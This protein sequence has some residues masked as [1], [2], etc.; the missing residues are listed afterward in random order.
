MT[1]LPDDFLGASAPALRVFHLTRIGFP[2]LPTLLPSALRL[3]EL[4]LLDIP[5]DGYISPEAM[6][7]SLEALAE[8]RI[9]F[10]GFKSLIRTS[11]TN[12]RDH[13]TQTVIPSL[14]TFDFHGIKGY[15][16]DLIA[17]IDTPQLDYF[18]ISYFNQ[19]DFHIP[20]LSKFVGRTQS[21]SLARFKRARVDFGINNVDVGLYGQ[22]EEL[23]ET[24]F[25]FQIPCRG[26]DWQVS[27]VAQSIRK[28]PNP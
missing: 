25:S 19:L 22:R 21:L 26:L 13:V 10:I 17:Q 7:T 9:L 20:Q 8:L 12:H 28:N 14:T 3:F 16:E 5:H 11:R 27:H 4:Q 18:R 23:L 24:H 1:S 15:L 2:G 6:V